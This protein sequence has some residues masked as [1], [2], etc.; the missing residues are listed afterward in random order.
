M[1]L[2]TCD[3]GLHIVGLIPPRSEA[4]RLAG[5]FGEW[6]CSAC[7][8][9]YGF[10]SKPGQERQRRPKAHRDLVKRFGRGYCELC[11]RRESELPAGQGLDGHHVR[12]FSNDGEPKRENTWIVCKAC[13]TLIDYVRDYFGHHDVLNEES[14]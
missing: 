7:G 11:L 1:I 8:R 6:R 10:M 9:H 4:A 3:C 5:H 14:Q 12:E 2:N 13:H